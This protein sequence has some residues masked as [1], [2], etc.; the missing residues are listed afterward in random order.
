M[1]ARSIPNLDDIQYDPAKPFDYM[2]YLATT[3]EAVGGAEH[4]WWQENFERKTQMA[5]MG[6]VHVSQYLDDDHNIAASSHDHF[7]STGAHVSFAG[8]NAPA[9]PGH[10]GKGTGKDRRQPALAAPPAP[11]AIEDR[12]GKGDPKRRTA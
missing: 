6:V 5:I 11:L 2:F 9:A 7:A 4:R 3:Q 8:A 12:I 10:P 1:I